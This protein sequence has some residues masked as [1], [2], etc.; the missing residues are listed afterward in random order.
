MS[1]P[2]ATKTK[3]KLKEKFMITNTLISNTLKIKIIKERL[4]GELKCEAVSTMHY[5]QL[6]L[7]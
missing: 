7:N 5:F 4:K 2:H 3:M 6:D 1:Q